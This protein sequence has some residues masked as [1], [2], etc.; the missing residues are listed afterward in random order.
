MG[1][2]LSDAICFFRRAFQCQRQSVVR[3]LQ[4]MYRFILVESASMHFPA[5]IVA[6][7]HFLATEAHSTFESRV[8]SCLCSVKIFQADPSH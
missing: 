1:G 8:V 4:L 6:A 2:N 5:L 3:T 7:V